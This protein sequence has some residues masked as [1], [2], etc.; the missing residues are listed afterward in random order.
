MNVVQ[1]IESHL[2]ACQVLSLNTLPGASGRDP[3]HALLPFL[4]ICVD[5]HFPFHDL[6]A[7]V[8]GIFPLIPQ[9]KLTLIEST[10]HRLS[11]LLASG[12]QVLSR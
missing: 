4:H 5:D 11:I 2:L 12:L 9:S 3:M 10:L 7:S 6:C 1:L 8:I